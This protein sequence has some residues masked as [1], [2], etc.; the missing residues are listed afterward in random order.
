MDHIK[1]LSKSGPNTA[2]NV[3]PACAGCNAVKST[4]PLDRFDLTKRKPEHTCF[5]C[6]ELVYMYKNLPSP[7]DGQL[8]DYCMRRCYWYPLRTKEKTESE[9]EE[10]VPLLLKTRVAATGGQTQFARET[11]VN[12]SVLSDV[13]NGRRDLGT[14]LLEA[15]GLE[16][17]VVYLSRA[18][19]LRP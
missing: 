10:A 18:A 9:G 17:T 13:L 5:T 12:R 15:L 11:G 14:S 1:P 16:R 19:V 2:S 4:L 3:V 7:E 8:R 6:G